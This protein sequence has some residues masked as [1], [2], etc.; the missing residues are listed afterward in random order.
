MENALYVGLSRQVVLRRQLAVVA[1]NIANA[2]TPGYKAQRMQ[3]GMHLVEAWRDG[4]RRGEDM[5]MVVDRSVMR[6]T[7]P[8]QIERTGNPLDVAIQG[9]GYLVVETEFGPRYTRAGRLAIDADGQL[10]DSNRLPLLGDDDQPIAVPNGSGSLV[11]TPD[12]SISGQQ[13]PIGRLKLVSFQREGEMQPLG[14]GLM[15]SNE[16]PEEAVDAKVSQGMLEGSNVQPILEMTRMIEISRRYQSTQRLLQDEHN[17][18]RD[19]IS[20]LAGTSQR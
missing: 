4:P 19:S 8:G 1:N 15:A 10:V 5:A 9:D 18:Q 17:R 16:V 14:G 20:R 6:D 11:I 2:D 3:F 7:R 12:G 13:G